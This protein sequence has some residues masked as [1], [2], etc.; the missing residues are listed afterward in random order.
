[1]LDLGQA[2]LHQLRAAGV[3]DASVDMLGLC[4]ACR[5]DLFYSYRRGARG[6]L[7]TAAAVPAARPAAPRSRVLESPSRGRT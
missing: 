3:P 5:L 1:M 2:N 4:T 7:V 6:R